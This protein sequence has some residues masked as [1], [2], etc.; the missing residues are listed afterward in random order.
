[1]SRKGKDRT[2]KRRGITPWKRSLLWFCAAVLAAAGLL[3]GFRWWKAGSFIDQQEAAR[4][5]ADGGYAQVSAYLSRQSALKEE[6]VRELEY[7]I[8]QSLAQDSIEQDSDDTEAKLWEDCYSAQGKLYIGYNGRTLEVS[9]VGTGGEYFLFHPL[10]MLSGSYY[11][12]DSL[13]KDEVLIDAETAWKL[14]GSYDVIGR[15][16]QVGEMTHTISGVFRKEEGTFYEAA[17]EPD[18]LIYVH[19][20]TLLQYDIESSGDSGDNSSD[21]NS[22][23]ASA[24]P[25]AVSRMQNTDTGFR[26]VALANNVS[27]S[28][29]EK[30]AD[31]AKTVPRTATAYSEGPAESA[32]SA[33]ND[34]ASSPDS[35]GEGTA[36]SETDTSSDEGAASESASDDSEADNSSTSADNSAAGS[37]ENSGET[38][39][40]GGNSDSGTEAELPEGT[41]TSNTNVTDTGRITEYQIVMPSPVEGYAAQILEKALGEERDFKVVDNT[42][43]YST[44]SLLSLLADYGTRG[45]RLKEIHYPYWENNAVGWEDLFALLLVI[46][47]LLY[48]L[49]ILLLLIMVIHYFRHKRWTVAGNFRNLQ[50]EIYERQSRKRYPEY[51]RERDAEESEEADREREDGKGS[52]DS[53][54]KTGGTVEE[55]IKKEI[56]QENRT[57]FRP[58]GTKRK[59]EVYEEAEKDDQHPDSDSTG[60]VDNS[61]RGRD[62]SE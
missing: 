53:G 37:T 58:V 44:R 2:K 38:D 31:A 33:D 61:M 42:E 46:E 7:T 22:D 54:E 59:E 35:S 19:Y 13:M 14:F 43:R 27:G 52:S 11:E 39:T 4:W 55:E 49:V 29:Q 5:S 28:E 48:V 57:P 23:S 25:S 18:Y 21:E 1:M 20:K 26:S 51:Y 50:D 15:T 47:W 6:D 3:H 60:A 10:T 30:N 24:S 17:G 62:E 41:G 45:M 12:P 40:G 8:T 9:A 56:G 34:S 32:E 36:E 16:L